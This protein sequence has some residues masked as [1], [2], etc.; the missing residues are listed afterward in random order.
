MHSKVKSITQSK[1]VREGGHCNL[2]SSTLQFQHAG[3]DSQD[4]PHKVKPGKNLGR[5]IED[6]QQTF[7]FLII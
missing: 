2:L 3:S 7:D 1:L 5:D 6:D 4:Y